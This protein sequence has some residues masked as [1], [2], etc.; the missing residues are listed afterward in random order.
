ME[1]KLPGNKQSG[2]SG[3]VADADENEFAYETIRTG[4]EVQGWDDGGTTVEF[5]GTYDSTPGIVA[6][7]GTRNAPDGGWPRLSDPSPSDVT[8][9]VDEDGCEDSERGNSTGEAAGLFA[10]SGGFR[11]Q[12]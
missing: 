7:K 9:R 5:D 10:F 1:T 12:P 11:I 2:A 8:V 6:S 4:D 3:T